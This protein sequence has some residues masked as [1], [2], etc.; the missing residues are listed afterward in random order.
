[1]LPAGDAF[2]IDTTEKDIETAFAIARA[3][4]AGAA[5]RSPCRPA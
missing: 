2:V 1:L 4:V 5:R 3:Y